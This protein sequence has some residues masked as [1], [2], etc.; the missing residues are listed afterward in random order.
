M[1]SLFAGTLARLR[2]APTA[3]NFGWLVVDKVVRLTLGVLVGMWVARYLG[4][5]DYGIMNYGLALAGLAAV[6]PALGLDLVVRRQLVREPA[7]AGQILGTT[8]Y[9]RLVVALLVYGLLVGSAHFLEPNPTARVAIAMAGASVLL[10]PVLAIDLWFQSQLLSKYTVVAQSITFFLSSAVRVWLIL[11][12]AGLT[13]F[14]YVLAGETLLLST[15]LLAVYLRARQRIAGWRWDRSAAQNLLQQSWPLALSAIATLVYVKVDQVML[16]A[17]SGPAE[18]GVYTAASRLMEILHTLPIMLAASFSPELVRARSKDPQAYEHAM[19]RFFNVAAGA[20]W[21]ATLTTVALA[22]W[23]VPLAFGPAYAR[24]SDM[25][26]I[27]AFS[28][29][30]IAMGV[31]RQEYLLNEGWLRFQLCTTLLGAGLNVALN[32]W[33]IP[34]WGGM[35]AAAVTLASH[36]VA[37]LVTSSAWKPARTVARWQWRALAGGWS[38]RLRG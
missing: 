1:N 28:L 22:R 2:S 9:L 31:A 34:R 16:R 38:L 30:M 27:L 12:G 7:Q 17:I 29:P 36:L 24:A 5:A 11:R 23:L 21:L 32:L 15:L 18:T 4:P 26:M 33:A 20:S 13:A 35:G 3:A 10:Q 8:F 37:D 25:L 14:L 6:V 19:R